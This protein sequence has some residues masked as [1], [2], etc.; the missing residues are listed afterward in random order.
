MTSQG[1][2]RTRPHTELVP[3]RPLPDQTKLAEAVLALEAKGYEV[4]AIRLHLEDH[5][6]KCAV[7]LHLSPAPVVGRHAE[8]VGDNGWSG[9]YHGQNVGTTR[10]R[11]LETLLA[12]VEGL[13]D[14]QLRDETG[15]GQHD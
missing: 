4:R 11:N 13:P 6:K 1:R 3:F 14:V 7:V 5:G 2:H 15:A 12:Y 10:R 9:K 8:L